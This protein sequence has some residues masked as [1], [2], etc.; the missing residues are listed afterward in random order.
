MLLT[1]SNS[2][3][4]THHIHVAVLLLLF[5]VCVCSNAREEN[6][7]H[8][9]AC[10]TATCRK[11]KSYM[12]AHYCGESPAG[13]GPDDGCEPKFPKKP[14]NGVEVLANYHCVW[15]AAK[16][17]Q[18]CGQ[19]GQPSESVRGILFNELRRL[20]LPA[21]ASGQTRFYVMKSVASGW[22]VA[23]ATYSR[24]AGDDLELCE[25]IVVIDQGSHVSVLRELPFQK[26][27]VDVPSLT[28][29]HLIDL[30]DVDGD[31]QMDIILEG[32]A[33]EDHWLEVVSLHDGSPHTAFSGLGYYL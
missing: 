20:G 4:A 28:T 9:P 7:I 26:T 11:I 30:A 19:V 18:V 22:S 12:R 15:S 8:R 16:Q 2:S 5:L 25:V 3:K 10:S 6:D 14:Q 1:R 23:G 13:N 17:D 33:Y 29:W 24:T 27:D 21:N 31:G 32:D